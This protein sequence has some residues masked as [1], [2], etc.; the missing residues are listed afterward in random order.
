MEI[1]EI[2][3][4]DNFGCIGG[5]CPETCCHGWLIPLED[6]DLSR[7]KAQ[8]G[9][10]GTRLFLAYALTDEPV[11][12]F[13][14][15]TCPFL[16]RKGFCSLQLKKGHD[17]IP[18][19][20]RQFPRYYRNY[21]VFEERILD[22]SCIEAAKLFL[23][24][25]GDFHF[26]SY[27]GEAVSGLCTTNDDRDFLYE[28]LKARGDIISEIDTASDFASFSHSLNKISAH[29]LLCQEAYLNGNN[30]FLTESP[31][32][33]FDFDYDGNAFFGNPVFPFSVSRLN[34]LMS[35]V[36]YHRLLRGKIPTLYKLCSL[37]FRKRKS[38]FSSDEE[39]KR[40]CESF[41]ERYPLSLIHFKAYFN[42]YIYQYYLRTHE[43]YSFNRNVK[44][45]FIHLNMIFM[46]SVLYENEYHSLTDDEL[47]RIIAVYNR[48]AYFSYSI[49]DAMY[50]VFEL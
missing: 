7:F 42:Y 34:Y 14:S 25:K 21:G 18:R 31:L 40:L 28:L 5:A 10:L 48:R 17:F 23:S 19:V 43:D 32:S 45:G 33:S 20:C 39:W 6:E 29:A 16:N 8:K 4:F 1:R 26:V 44:T 24:Q 2:S 36:F 35:T 37:Y 30:G 15:A 11:F 38:L 22:L 27:E 9:V 46:F 41:I 50:K 12:N 3:F 49:L 47:A 13:G